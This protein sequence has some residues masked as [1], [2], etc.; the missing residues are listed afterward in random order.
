MIPSR[1]ISVD[2]AGALLACWAAL[3]GINYIADPLHWKRMQLTADAARIWSQAP[4][5]LE[6]LFAV[7]P[8]HAAGAGAAASCLAAMALAGG[9]PAVWFGVREGMVR[10]AFGL[11]TGSLLVLGLGLAGLFA[12]AVIWPAVAALA[13]AGGRA[14]RRI[15][16]ATA[17]RMPAVPGAVPH[18]VVLAVLPLAGV[19]LALNVLGGLAPETG[20][21]S[22]IQHLAD[23][24][25]YLAA[26]RIAFN[27]LSFL[28]QHPAGI[29]MLYG[30]VLPAGGDEAAKLL[31]GAFGLLTC[32][33]AWAWLRRRMPGSDALVLA[34]VLYLTP[35][36]GILSARAYIDQGLTFFTAASLLAPWGSVAQGALIGLAIGTK[37][38][39]GFLLLGWIAVYAAA[40][41]PRSVLRIAAGA[42]A[43]A[44]AWGARN[45]FN[46][47][48]PVYPFGFL[49]LGGLAW[50]ARSAGEYATE[51]SG[52]GRVSGW[53]AH[54]AIPWDA[55]VHD[56]GA[57]DDGSLGPLWLMAAPLLLLRSGGARDARETML[58]RLVAVL[59]IL[60]LVSPRQVRYALMLLPPT[61]AV[62]APA[63]VRA[64]DRWPAGWR[65][66]TA[67]VPPLLFIQLQISFAALYL[68]VN[69][70]SVA[71][72]MLP[73]G[74]YLS[75]IME[76]RDSH[77]GRSLYLALPL[78][79]AGPLPGTARTYMLGDAKVYYLP[80]DWRVNALFNPPLLARIIRTSATPA[81]AVK[82]FRQRGITHVL[83]NVGGSIH[84]EYTHHLL[85]WNDR[86]FALLDRLATGWWKPLYRM[87]DSDGDPMYLLYALAP[88]RYPDPPYLPG[89]DT[90]LAGVETLAVQGDR[91][92]ARDA[93]EVLIRDFPSSGWMRRRARLAAIP[94][95]GVIIRK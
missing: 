78:A 40:R 17:G 57:L 39:G 45:W 6:R 88:G 69:P 91:R 44:G 81:E 43:A 33:A 94:P 61:L 95:P 82:R 20:Y 75:R 19:S 35:F 15:R 16:S 63:L 92:G 87:S 58:R 4:F 18:W 56:H 13:L 29:E 23:P 36:T 89:I 93:A 77:T 46:T 28:A 51:L 86:E 31:H 49:H 27:D 10:L 68:W 7:L 79:L 21:D 80:G 83:Y 52:Y 65:V 55:F 12:P 59:W 1:R 47:G 9:G 71:A 26:H 90:R 50:D 76:P 42:A 11:G 8:A 25:A 24:R 53:P 54:G 37:Y 3:V 64:R 14:G 38:L 41:R 84:I 48:N 62:L 60:W 5:D 2:P 74:E 30:A 85:S 67:L 70:L 73:R 22:L 34:A 32:W 72:G 66:A